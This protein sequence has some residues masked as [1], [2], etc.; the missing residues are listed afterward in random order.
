MLLLDNHIEALKQLESFQ[1]YAIGHDG[2]SK[3]TRI[4]GRLK[5][6]LGPSGI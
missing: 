5:K 1:E 6:I 4:S 3:G 2:A